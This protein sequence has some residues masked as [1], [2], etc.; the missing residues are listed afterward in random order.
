MRVAMNLVLASQGAHPAAQSIRRFWTAHVPPP[1]WV[2]L[3]RGSFGPSRGDA[4]HTALR[5]LLEADAGSRRHALPPAA[6]P[7]PGYHAT[8]LAALCALIKEEQ[9]LA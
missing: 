2:D 4:G 9:A 6:L 7:A 5:D 1:D 8:A 3:Q